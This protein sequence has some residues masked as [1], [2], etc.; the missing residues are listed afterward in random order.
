MR[1][2]T[3][4]FSKPNIFPFLGLNIVLLIIFMTDTPMLCKCVSIES[5]KIQ[6]WRFLEGADRQ[7]SVIV[8]V[9]RDGKI[10]FDTE[11]V[12]PD[13]L[14]ARLEP[15]RV[16]ARYDHS[17]ATRLYLKVDAHTRY[18]KVKDVLNMVPP[19]LAQRISFITD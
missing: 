10:Y 15:L 19:E 13:T 18:G 12:A 5:V 6:H 17:E 9:L 8:A 16:R 7:D 4:L 14:V 2:S 3:Q 1:P 11:Q